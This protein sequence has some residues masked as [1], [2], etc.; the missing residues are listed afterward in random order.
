LASRVAP[1]YGADVRF[2]MV[3]AVVASALVVS[4]LVWGVSEFLLGFFY[5]IPVVL[6]SLMSAKRSE[7]RGRVQ[8]HLVLWMTTRP[9]AFFIGIGWFGWYGGPVL[10]GVVIALESLALHARRRGSA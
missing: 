8:L 10:L 2:S 1:A 4:G 3:M 5:A 7:P 9:L 6:V